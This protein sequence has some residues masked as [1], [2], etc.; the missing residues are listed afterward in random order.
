MATVGGITR[1]YGLH[2][3]FARPEME[4]RP[5]KISRSELKRISAYFRPYWVRWTIIIGCIAAAAGLNVL[6]PFC[7]A[8]ILDRAIP[9][10]NV[11]LLGLL[12]G[13]MVALAVAS[14]LIG[15]LE[16]SLTARVGQSIMFDIR[17]QLYTHLQR[18]S[19]PWIYLG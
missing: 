7:V 8:A 14:G 6:P 17:N 19:H 3:Y 13:A 1:T 2:E 16:Q 5:P 18:M 10:G 11:H 9:Q 15:V 4:G 12:A